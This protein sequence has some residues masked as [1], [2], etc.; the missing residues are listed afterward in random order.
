MSSPAVTQLVDYLEEHKIVERRQDPTDQRVV[1]VDYAPGM[2]D[3]ARRMM[4]GRRRRLKEAVNSLAQEEARV[5]KGLRSMAES[6]E[7]AY[8]EETVEPHS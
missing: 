4:E 6:F 2:Q 5:L 3:I 1:L 7:A 8:K